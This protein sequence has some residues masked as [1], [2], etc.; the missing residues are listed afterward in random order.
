M[1]NEVKATL[2]N[3]DASL[4]V[5]IKIESDGGLLDSLIALPNQRLQEMEAAME[6][7]PHALFQVSGDVFNFGNENYILLRESLL[8][9]EFAERNHPD[10]VPIDPNAT[11]LPENADKD[12]VADIVKELE[13][14]TGGLVKSIRSAAANPIETKPESVIISKLL[15]PFDFTT[16]AN[17]CREFAP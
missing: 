17:S 5:R 16:F 9:Q 12:S 14:A 6:K 3:S 1:I 15:S 10:F 2:E 7:D 4:P 11:T 8:L 13:M